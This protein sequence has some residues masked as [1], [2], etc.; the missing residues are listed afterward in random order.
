MNDKIDNENI[1]GQLRE[2][3]EEADLHEYLKSTF[4]GYTK[5][6]VKEY[7][8]NLRKQHLAAQENFKRNLDA[9][10][11]EKEILRNDYDII[12]DRYNKLSLEYDNLTESIKTIELQ[13]DYSPEK[14]IAFKKNAAV[15][16]E[17]LK[18]AEGEN[19]SLK[20]TINLL[21]KE[22]HELN[23]N[24]K[25]SNKELEAQNQVLLAEKQESRKLRDEIIEITRRLNDE[26]NEVKY[27][28]NT[29]SQEKYTQL[30]SQIAQLNQQLSALTEVA[31][32]HA[33]E[34]TLKDRDIAS[35]NDE[36]SFLK[37]RLDL[38]QKT[39]QMLTLQNNK[40]LS[41]NEAL[42]NVLE[43]EY[44]KS[45]DLINEKSGLIIDKII[46]QQN[47]SEAELKLAAMEISH[48]KPQAK[49]S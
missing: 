45:I 6:S 17:E 29:V 14:F 2:R 15:L 39:E 42:K 10:L 5:K 18:K 25:L 34:G 35:L 9:V 28:K 11:R 30:N 24:I 20:N 36:N 8:S 49:N 4:G 41:A 19:E 40:L 22:M 43:K 16:E 46:A 26:K 38:M 27:L 44:K 13:N 48:S 47:L 7:F 3:T 32:R 31:K 23:E 37:E 21:N 33:A 1:V 12:L